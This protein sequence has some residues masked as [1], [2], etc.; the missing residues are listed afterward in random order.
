V[1]LF[2]MSGEVLPNARI[3]LV[4]PKGFSTR[5]VAA[6]MAEKFGLRGLRITAMIGF[7]VG[8]LWWRGCDGVICVVLYVFAA[9]VLLLAIIVTWTAKEALDKFA[10]DY[11]NGTWLTLDEKGIGGEVEGESE[12]SFKMPW[13]NFRRVNERHRMWLLET[14]NGNW[15]VL[16]TTEFSAEAWALMRANQRVPNPQAKPLRT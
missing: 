5:A 1:A 3:L 8:Y 7:M 14:V 9:T 6:V 16:P 10:R 12:K 15:M 4:L 2:S 11:A 13:Q